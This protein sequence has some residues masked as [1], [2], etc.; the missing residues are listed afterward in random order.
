MHE[1]NDGVENMEELDDD[2]VEKI[3]KAVKANISYAEES[4][5]DAV[6]TATRE[7]GGSQVDLA[8]KGASANMQSGHM[9]ISVGILFS[10]DNS[11][12]DREESDTS[13][14]SAASAAVH[15]ESSGANGGRNFT[16]TLSFTHG[17]RA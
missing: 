15:H 10:D 16:T 6:L 11:D 14:G 3:N 7:Q 12:Q 13:P 17:K 1:R 2:S 8:G 5:K 4:S 9:P